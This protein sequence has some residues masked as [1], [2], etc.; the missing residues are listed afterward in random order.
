MIWG[1]AAGKMAPGVTYIEYRNMAGGISDI[2]ITNIV[3]IFV[4]DGWMLIR[5]DQPSVYE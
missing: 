5:S 2:G 3:N 1:T 4:T